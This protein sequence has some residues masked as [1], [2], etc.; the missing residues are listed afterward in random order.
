MNVILLGGSSGSLVEHMSQ[1]DVYDFLVIDN[2]DD[3]FP[4]DKKGKFLH[5]QYEEAATPERVAELFSSIDARKPSVLIIDP[6]SPI[7]GASLAILK[8]MADTR[9][10][11]D[12]IMIL[13]Y[14]TYFLSK[15]EI[16]HTRV[17]F[18]VIQEY[19]RSGLIPDVYLIDS[20]TCVSAL[21][22]KTLLNV[23]SKLAEFIGN[24]IHNFYYAKNSSKLRDKTIEY[25][26]VC[27]IGTFGLLDFET[28]QVFYLFPLKAFDERCR[29]PIEANHHFFFTTETLNNE[30]MTDQLQTILSTRKPAYDAIGYSII[31][32]EIEQVIVVEKTS[33]TQTLEKLT[34]GN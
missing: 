32:T 1:F 30:N 26:E 12:V 20:E 8:Y 2:R 21:T 3:I 13:P 33:K 28:G 15:E 22:N 9:M 5:E 23:D 6:S 7:S 25:S 19:S 31:E 17:T 34:N 14:D 16:S 27:K 24:T 10:E 11:F 4:V 29:F 18:G